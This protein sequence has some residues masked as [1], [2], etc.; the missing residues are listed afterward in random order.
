M[1]ILTTSP[2]PVYTVNVESVWFPQSIAP[3]IPA[4]PD[5]YTIRYTAFLCYRREVD[6]RLTICSSDQVVAHV[7]GQKVWLLRLSLV[8]LVAGMVS[9]ILCTCVLMCAA[10]AFLKPQVWG[11]P[12]VRKHM[13]TQMC[14]PDVCTHFCERCSNCGV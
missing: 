4:Y 7:N 6:I 11:G 14:M 8:F 12:Q 3:I 1:Q 13:C 2:Q 5:D 10:R 9:S